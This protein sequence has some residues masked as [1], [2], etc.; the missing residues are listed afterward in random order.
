MYVK[1]NNKKIPAET[2]VAECINAD[3]GTGA[4]IESGNHKWK[5]NWADL[6]Q[7]LINKNNEQIFNIEILIFKILKIKVFKLA[8]FSF[9][10]K[11]FVSLI[12]SIITN[13]NKN[14]D[15]SLNL[16]KEN[17]LNADFNTEIFVDQKLIKKNEVNPINSQPKNKTKQ[18]PLKTKHIIL[19]TKLF[20]KSIK[21]SILG[22]YL[23][24]ENVNA[25]T[26]TEIVSVKKKKL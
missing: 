18:L 25:Y 14:S 16:L 5:P 4:S 26:K 21:R 8:K 1:R 17:A 11:I 24:Y 20:N 19:I 22:S 23:K 9:I 10:K 13:K 6:I 7:I 3:A 15:T 2:N 12:K